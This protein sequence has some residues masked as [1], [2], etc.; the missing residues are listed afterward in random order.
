[1]VDGAHR[2]IREDRSQPALVDPT[3]QATYTATSFPFTDNKERDPATG[4][5]EGALDN[6]RARTNQPKVFYTNT[7]VEIG[8]AAGLRRSCTQAR[9]FA[10]SSI[11]VERARISRRVAA[12]ARRLSTGGNQRAAEEQSD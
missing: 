4:A 1:M 2:R 9:W 8:A 6:Q 5:V 3:T 10:R 12:R 11:A 7:G